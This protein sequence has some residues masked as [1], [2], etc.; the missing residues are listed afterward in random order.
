MVNKKIWL[1]CPAWHGSR[2]NDDRTG[3]SWSAGVRDQWSVRFFSVFIQHL[4]EVCNVYGILYFNMCEQSKVP[5]SIVNWISWTSIL[6]LGHSFFSS[7]KMP[8][9]TS[10]IT[11][12]PRYH[13][14]FSPTVVC[15]FLGGWCTSWTPFRILKGAGQCLLRFIFG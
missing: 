2:F 6:M 9:W 7:F 14:G 4:G 11:I 3:D 8:K 5:S 10:N 1:V 12:L 15:A 13:F